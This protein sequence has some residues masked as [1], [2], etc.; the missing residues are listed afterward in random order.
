MGQGRRRAGAEKAASDTAPGHESA[1]ITRPPPR[2]AILGRR[3]PG[4]QAS[5]GGRATGVGNR[6]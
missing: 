5:I 6:L 4:H 3:C 2:V 1:R